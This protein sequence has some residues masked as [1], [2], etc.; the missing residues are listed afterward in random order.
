MDN[1]A[2]IKAVIT[3]DDKASSV[4]KSFGDNSVDASKKMMAGVAAAGAAI[5]AFGVES[6]KAFEDS[7]SRIAQTNAVLQSTGGIAGVTAD[8]VTKLSS[9]LE[10]QTSFSDEDVRSVENMLLT[11]TSI[12]KDIFP[13]A[14][15]TVLDMA[16]AL[17]EDTQ[18]AAIQLGKALQDPVLGVTALRRVGVNFNSAQQDV[19]KNLVD[20]GNAAKA[21]QLILAELTRE[22]GGSAVAAGNTFAGSLAK[23][24]NQFNN[25]EETVG[26]TLV[27][28]LMPLM[29]WI[30]NW[31]A[32]V[33]EAGGL[34][35]YLTGVFDRNKNTIIAVAGAIAGALVPAIAV[36]TFNFAKLVLT[37]SPWMALG[38][39]IAL[40]ILHWSDIMRTF[41]GVLGDVTSA[42]DDFT[43]K[44]KNIAGDIESFGVAVQ[45]KVIKTLDD[46]AKSVEAFGKSVEDHVVA[47]FK[48]VID[49]IEKHKKGLEDI[50]ETI[51]VLVLPA[52][53][54]LSIQAITTATTTAASWVTASATASAAWL[55]NFAKISAQAVVTGAI[56]TVQAIK[57]GAIWVAQAV[58]TGA[59][60]TLRFAIM[61]AQAV[62]AGV[63]YSAQAAISAGAWIAGFI[64]MS[65][66]AVATGAVF[67]AQ[68]V[69]A[70]IAWVLAL[71]PVTLAITA[72]AALALV[73]IKNWSDVKQWLSDFGGFAE[74][75]F[76]S[77]W[78]A[79]YSSFSNV[80]GFIT[81]I[82]KTEFDGV[83]SIWNNTVGKLHFSIPSWVPSLGGKGFDMPTI[84]MLANGGIV[85]KP[86]LAMIG[87]AG[88]EAVV[89]L[90]KGGR[91]AGSTINI[92][93]NA[94]AFMGSQ[95]QARQFATQIW[96]S[97]QQVAAQKNTTVSNLVIGGVSK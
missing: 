91:M 94:Q 85:T 17:G 21:Q 76:F 6:V 16:T 24:K 63:V 1:T 60:W 46:A 73:V 29:N 62:A 92:S 56:N 81:G 65:A 79:I 31:V 86:T 52:L 61:S 44:V 69:A 88:P 96:Q 33:Q 59:A 35:A 64:L 26:Q 20:T 38:A 78:N 54:K 18:S 71:G 2:N 30:D 43:T 34:T 10:R 49:W 82:F 40:I 32:K 36:M 97:L 4:L 80:K 14:T 12:G 45:E 11:F 39:A 3:A 58:V 28:A 89:P 66:G 27:E 9:A 5:V 95:I 7:Q 19:I 22:F 41:H 93:I 37:L 48:D 70:G 23:L 8:A 42:W 47:P 57:S 75:I 15:K 51:T 68:A 83:A 87:E 55:I 77:I 90:S 72:I 13:Q 84:P 74:N 25:L 50:V 53:I 67:V